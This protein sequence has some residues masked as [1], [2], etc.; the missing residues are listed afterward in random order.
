ME[1]LIT[2][3]IPKRLVR[4]MNIY[5]NKYH[6]TKLSHSSAHLTLVPPFIL[7][8]E[9]KNLILE[10]KN[11][12]KSQESFLLRTNGLGYFN[13]D[14]IYFKPSSSP[15]LRKLQANLKYLVYKN[16]RKGGHDRYWKFKTYHPHITISR[17]KPDKI[18]A[19]KKELQ[20]LI[21]NRQFIV[22]A[23][24]LYIRR[25]G[26][27]WILNK[28]FVFGKNPTKEDKMR[29]AINTVVIQ[30]KN[31]LVV[32]KRNTW[33]LPGGKPQEGESDIQCLIREVTKEEIPGTRLTN[34]RFYGEFRGKTPHRGDL[35]LARVYLAEIQGEI[36]SGAE[37]TDARW[38]RKP[39]NYNLSEITG[40]I[41]KHLRKKGYL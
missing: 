11:Y 10:M 24:E 29:I 36:K 18:K 15:Q 37:I 40:K 16:Y 8:G 5:K 33:I 21:Y 22:S 17:D 38:V 12:V 13:N 27:R 9:L 41:I 31:V 30:N 3:K 34:L 26:K 4:E 1:I 14:V 25:E 23:I 28:E 6:P 39:E 32:R 7:A 35:L 19:Y 20:G 2:I